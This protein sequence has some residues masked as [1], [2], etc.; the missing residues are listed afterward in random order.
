MLADPTSKTASTTDIPIIT[1]K[2]RQ[3]LVGDKLGYFQRSRLYMSTKV[4]LQL[5]LTMELGADV[6]KFV[7]KIQM[8]NF[9]NQVCVPY[10]DPDCVTL[11]IE[12]VSQMIAK[13]ARRIEKL[14]SIH[15]TDMSDGISN[16]LNSTINDTIET[17]AT[18]RRN[19]NIQVEKIHRN[20]ET[21]VIEPL[22][23]LNF[24]NDV[25]HG[26]LV[27][28]MKYLEGRK[29]VSTGA[30]TFECEVKS[31]R[32]HFKNGWPDHKVV[33]DIQAKAEIN[34]DI[35]E[36]ELR[37]FW[38]DFENRALY[39]TDLNGKSAN[40]F[41]FWA[42]N[43]MLFA[44]K[45]Y[46]DNQL[47][48]SRMILVCLKMI[49][50]F[51]ERL[52]TDVQFDILNQHHS[53][54]NP[55]IFNVLLLPQRIDMELAFEL[56]QYFQKRN[57]SG[58]DPSLIGEKCVTNESFSVK[59][60]KKNFG[61]KT[62]R[63]KILDLDA[64]NIS[65]K[66]FQWEAYQRQ[67]ENLREDIAAMPPCPVVYGQKICQP[68]EC[69]RCKK[70]VEISE[71]KMDVYEHL[72]PSAEYDEWAIVFELRVPRE[73]ACLRDILFDFVCTVVGNSEKSNMKNWIDRSELAGF[74]IPMSDQKVGLGSTGTNQPIAKSLHIDEQFDKFIIVNGSNCVFNVD[75]RQMPE[76]I[77]NEIIKGSPFFAA[78]KTDG[79]YAVLQWTVNGT[80]HTEN[81][82]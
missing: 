59:F 32:R 55:D 52:C 10:I 51:D 50:T 47:L 35:G 43:Y 69:E 62:I 23:C 31:Y 1:K 58:S 21:R 65:Q 82:V 64:L 28:L 57:I 2:L 27:D 4:L 39:S 71:I 56:Q 42:L 81:E 3:E 29:N 74:K 26:N 17:I 80:T 34:K 38:N 61:M 40:E 30:Q 9:F 36:V 68:F 37:I 66:R 76:P 72:L 54:I 11:N 12:L 8:L 49:K 46:I 60:A 14:N 18:I 15:P 78:L 25:Q 13:M 19:I 6:G 75:G 5:S 33:A 45:N 67:I 63:K 73:I 44:K 77:T 24:D 53:G 20:N 7:Y 70:D 48:S 41:R 79:E 16:M 22:K